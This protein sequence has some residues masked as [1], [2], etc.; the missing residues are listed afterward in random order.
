MASEMVHRAFVD[1]FDV[2]VWS[3]WCSSLCLDI[4]QA[5]D[6]LVEEADS[7]PQFYPAGRYP[8]LTELQACELEDQVRIL[9][10]LRD[11]SSV[12]DVKVAEVAETGKGRV[13]A[14]L[15]QVLGDRS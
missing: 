14:S 4:H 5:F 9:R 1:D 10:L 13:A 2:R 12:N 3:D 15:E 6:A 8:D 7:E 11:R